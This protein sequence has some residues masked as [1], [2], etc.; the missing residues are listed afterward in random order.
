VKK[1]YNASK[2]WSIDPSERKR[3][4]VGLCDI[5]N[6]LLKSCKLD[7]HGCN[8]G[9]HCQCH[10]WPTYY[11]SDAREVGRFLFRRKSSDSHQILGKETGRDR[12]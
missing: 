4:L 5:T 1:G 9:Y 8:T 12:Y 7:C 6:A 10:N 2:A 3:R 11:T